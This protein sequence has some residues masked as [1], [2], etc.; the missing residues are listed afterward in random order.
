MSTVPFRPAWWIALWGLIS[1][2]SLNYAL[3]A[4]DDHAADYSPFHSHVVIGATSPAERSQVLA[5]HTHTGGRTD[6]HPEAAGT[7]GASTPSA[8][9]TPDPLQAAH[10]NATGYGGGLPCAACAGACLL[11]GMNLLSASFPSP[12]WLVSGTALL[13]RAFPSAS[14]PEQPPR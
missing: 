12:I 9:S 5:N 4:F 10:G 13:F 1:A 11:A 2:L 8:T 14:P 7:A 3:P 6:T